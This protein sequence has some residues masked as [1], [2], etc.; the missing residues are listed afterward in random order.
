MKKFKVTMVATAIK[1]IFVS[2]K[3]KNSAMEKVEK[4]Y[5][6]EEKLDFTE[7]DSIDHINSIQIKNAVLTVK[8]NADSDALE[9]IR[10]RFDPNYTSAV[11]FPKHAGV[12]AS[13][14]LLNYT[15][16]DNSEVSQTEPL[17]IDHIQQFA[18]YIRET[19]G[20]SD[21]IEEELSNVIGESNEAVI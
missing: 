7:D 1:E 11:S 16:L 10:C 13:R 3:D 5:L 9:C 17:H 4:C 12:V 18:Q 20:N 19:I 2:A 21:I 6:D 14:I 8:V 15:N